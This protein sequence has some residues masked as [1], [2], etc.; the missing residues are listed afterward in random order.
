MPLVL[1]P[2]DCAKC[3]AAWR[4]ATSGKFGRPRL[5]VSCRAS[6]A[7]CII[8]PAVA[9]YIQPLRPDAYSSRLSSNQA[10]PVD[11]RSALCSSALNTVKTRATRQAQETSPRPR[12]SWLLPYSAAA[13]GNCGR[14]SGNASSSISVAA[15]L[16]S[17]TLRPSAR[18]SLISTL[19]LSGIPA[20]KAS[21]PRTMDS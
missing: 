17:S 10:L 6:K 8:H 18:I 5:S 4:Q 7:L 2:V 13:G 21:S 3:A 20:S 14:G 9:I 11:P 12:R 1:G 15:E 16:S 19:K